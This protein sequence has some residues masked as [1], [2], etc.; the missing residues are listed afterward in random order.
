MQQRVGLF[1]QLKQ[2]FVHTDMETA[3]VFQAEIRVAVQAANAQR[4]V[5]QFVFSPNV[6]FPFMLVHATIRA[7]IYFAVI[8]GGDK[9]GIATETELV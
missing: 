3:F 6:F 8:I 9:N 1:F 7:V 4:I 5:V 2:F